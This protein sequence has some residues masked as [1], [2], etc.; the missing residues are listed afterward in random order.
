MSDWQSWWGGRE[1]SEHRYQK[2]GQSKNERAAY[3]SLERSLSRS[4]C[5]LIDG[6]VFLFCLI[7]TGDTDLS[8]REPTANSSPDFNSPPPQLSPVVT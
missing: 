4:M 7:C 1:L 8:D 6:C 3:G 5:G 2:V